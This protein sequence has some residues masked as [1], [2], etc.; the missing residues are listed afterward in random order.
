MGTPPSGRSAVVLVVNRS[1]DAYVVRHNGWRVGTVMS[2]AS[3][4]L[5]LSLLRQGERVRLGLDPIGGDVFYTWDIPG[6]MNA[7]YEVV[8]SNSSRMMRTE[9][10]MPA[11]RCK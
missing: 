5:V 11:P 9:A 8:I 7:G 10:I 3:E 6:T 1:M 2:G 4:C